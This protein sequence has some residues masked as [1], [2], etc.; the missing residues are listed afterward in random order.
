MYFIIKNSPLYKDIKKKFMHIYDK[1]NFVP[2]NNRKD[3]CISRWCD[4]IYLLYTTNL[5]YLDIEKYLIETLGYSVVNN[6]II[7]DFFQYTISILSKEIG[8]TNINDKIEDY[9]GINIRMNYRIELY[10]NNWS[11]IN[12]EKYISKLNNITE[13][14]YTS[15]EELLQI[16]YTNIFECFLK[17]EKINKV[18][19]G[20]PSL[21][22][23]LKIIQNNK[24]KGEI[25]KLMN[26]KYIKSSYFDI[27]KNNLLTDEELLKIKSYIDD[28]VIIQ[29]LNNLLKSNYEKNNHNKP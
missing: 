11:I 27:I 22:S 7:K 28:P 24:H 6:Y 17:I 18:S 16:L 8:I 29:K 20:R 1:Y 4:L 25:K 26:D 15:S 2:F 12:I 21:P 9:E 3:N 19:R 13:D 5:P 10:K 23:E 14:Y